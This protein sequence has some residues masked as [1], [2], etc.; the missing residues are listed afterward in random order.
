[1][2]G[3]AVDDPGIPYGGTGAYSID[4]TRV[5]VHGITQGGLLE[6][7]DGGTEEDLVRAELDDVYRA[8]ARLERELPSLTEVYNDALSEKRLEK[9]GRLW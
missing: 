9:A 2:N 1:M 7:L 5:P 8:L 3:D 4:A 6:I